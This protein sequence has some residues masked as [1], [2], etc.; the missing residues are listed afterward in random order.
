MLEIKNI[1]K[2]YKT[3]NLIQKAL[4]NV[5]LNLRDNEFVAV[6]G[7]SGSGKTTLLNIIGGLDHYD[8]GDLIING[9]ST[10]D[11]KD[12]DFD[13][14]RNH[15][16]GFVFQSYNLIPHQTI[17][18]NVELALTI[19]GISK[20]E[21][22]QRALDA[23][24]AVGLKDQAHKKPNQMSGGQMQ[25]VA[26][27]RALVNNP[28]IVL[29]DEPTGALDTKTSVQV[30]ELLKEVAKD[31]LVI[32]VTHNPD[33]ANEY[34]NRIVNL[35]DGEIVGDSNPFIINES[36]IPT[37]NK[38]TGK[39]KMN[40]FTALSLSFNNLLTKKGR[41]ILTAFAGSIGI[42]GIALILSLS[43]GFQNYIDKIQEDT[44]SSYPLTINKES[45][46][47]TSIILAMRTSRENTGEADGTLTERQYLT[48][49]FASV[50]MNEL[51]EF[52]KYVEDH[53]DEI[54]DDVVNINYTYAISPL[55]YTIDTTNSLVKLNPNSVLSSF[56][57]SSLSS[58]TT[59]AY[60]AYGI[61]VFTEMS[62]D[63]ELIKENYELLKGKWPTNYDEMILVLSE[64]DG[65][66]D[67]LVYSLGLRD[68]KELTNM[69]TTHISGEEIENNNEP[70]KFTYDD[71]LNLDLRMINAYQLYKYNDKYNIYEDMSSD[72]S[73]MQDLYNRALKLKIVGIV[74][75]K[76]DAS[77]SVLS[78]GVNYTKALTAYIIDR[79]KDSTIVQKQLANKDIDV[80]SGKTFEERNSENK[81]QLNFEEMISIDKNK[82]SEAFTINADFS[83]LSDTEATQ[84]KIINASKA[85]A[86]DL[87]NME[88]TAYT[89]LNSSFANASKEIIN[90]YLTYFSFNIPD[91]N[92]ASACPLG[93]V[94]PANPMSGCNIITDTTDPN[95]EEE[96]AKYQQVKGFS[97]NPTNPT[98]IYVYDNK[99]LTLTSF[100]DAF[101]NAYKNMAINQSVLQMEE[102]VNAANKAFDSYVTSAR[103]LVDT[104][105]PLYSSMMIVN[106]ND[107]NNLDVNN[108]VAT[109][110]AGDDIQNQIKLL[111]NK[112]AEDYAYLLIAKGMGEVT[113]DLLKPL[114]SL[115]NGNLMS[116]DTNKFADA[117]KFNMSE[118]EL[119]RIMSAMMT[120]D[121]DIVS[122][123]TN[124]NNLSYQDIEDPSSISFY[125]DSFEAK[126][127][128]L[129]WLAKYNESVEEDKQINYT[130]ITGIL[131]SSVK[132]IVD[133]VTYVLIAFVSIS[134][135]VSSIM[136]AVITLISVMERTK[137]IGILRAMGA[138]KRNISSIF[139][140]ET[141]IIGLLSGLIGVITTKILIVPINRLIHSL[142]DNYNIN[143]TLPNKYALI[144]IIISIIL[145]IIAGFIPAKKAAKKDPVIA[146]RT[147]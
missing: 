143:A 36:V 79:A 102:L 112:S 30:M 144:L 13:T 65:I 14:Y 54:K 32:M 39:A 8:T 5:S 118:D 72:E 34:A 35:K 25:R 131:M 71:F 9:I 51:K 140:A 18:S 93:Y 109:A 2:T 91:I 117:F 52:K 86:Q 139:N 114:S 113:A 110:L 48:N 115:S 49:M 55:I 123:Q 107:L 101:V 84:N 45:T 31:R 80:F 87:L 43:Q 147:E 138:S 28:D 17:L 20:T 7:P 116:I 78:P 1:S 16:I 12:R 10:K 64:K 69:F 92:D 37:K 50:S 130:D 77:S 120:S 53:Y 3:G 29:A 63:E 41:T 33:L 4:D 100:A 73:Y 134:L 81:Q 136:I 141:F 82:L 61:G 40:F 75:A 108:I 121:S 137:E 38:K 98:M 126:E 57:S 124:L 70:L 119:R 142:T 44:L 83:S 22:R 59:S 146:L 106:N 26:I 122:A 94:T 60:A 24:D 56:T 135:I 97:M 88:T 95:Y 133:S 132:T 6:L 27:A 23:L 128:F 42:I 19:G 47:M 90:S 76:D 89:Q 11:Y 129:D 66:S 125:F 85:V 99:Y 111:A 15:S 74:I 67:L 62:D 58:L 21:R 127:N 68:F 103:A 104:T 96:L 46:D 145:T 105:N